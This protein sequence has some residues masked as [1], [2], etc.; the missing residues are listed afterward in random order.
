MREVEGDSTY[1]R[2]GDVKMAC[3]DLCDVA[4]RKGMPA[5][6]KSWNCQKTNF[7]LEPE[8]GAQT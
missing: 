4:A 5:D 8:D 3:R 7:P 2:E 1:R 6:T